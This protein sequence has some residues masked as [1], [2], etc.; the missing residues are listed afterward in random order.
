M[1]LVSLVLP[2][3]NAEAYYRCSYSTS[4]FGGLVA[5][6]R[7]VSSPR[8]NMPQCDCQIST[9][10]RSVRSCRSR[11]CGSRHV[12]GLSVRQR[13]AHYGLA[14]PH[15]YKWH[16]SS[17][18]GGHSTSSQATSTA[19]AVSPLQTLVMSPIWDKPG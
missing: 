17:Q 7:T 4:L 19:M 12:F 8:C 1:N 14:V 11:A 10:I 3:L 16:M 2:A 18:A 15:M 9:C 5:L 6:P 13:G